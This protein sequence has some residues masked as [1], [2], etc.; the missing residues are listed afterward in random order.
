MCTKIRTF[1]PLPFYLTDLYLH[2]C[3][4]NN[5]IKNSH[6][7]EFTLCDENPINW[8]LLLRFY[9]ALWT[10]F[11]ETTAALISSDATSTDR[12]AAFLESDYELEFQSIHT[13]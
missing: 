5:T 4:G 13:C 1:T 12:V 2:V 3:I 11:V 8:Q 6:L 7:V 9:A 10:A